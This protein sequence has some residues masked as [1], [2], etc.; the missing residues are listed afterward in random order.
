MALS[1]YRLY[2]EEVGLVGAIACGTYCIRSKKTPPTWEQ[3]MF[4]EDTERSS[5]RRFAGSGT[6]IGVRFTLL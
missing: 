2:C 4:T 6:A 1:G 3:N 5:A